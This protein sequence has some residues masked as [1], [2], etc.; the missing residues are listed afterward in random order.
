MTTA[1]QYAELYAS[2]RNKQEAVG[3][4]AGMF[5]QETDLETQK[6]SG[7]PDSIPID[8][9]KAVVMQQ[10]KKW[11]EFAHLVVDGVCPSWYE[12]FLQEAIPDLFFCHLRGVEDPRRRMNFWDPA[13]DQNGARI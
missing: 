11:K 8:E 12:K 9:I 10:S 3:R 1:E 6:I 5:L 7:Y 4:I 13:R 2:F